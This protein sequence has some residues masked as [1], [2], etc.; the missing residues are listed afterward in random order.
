MTY[1]R[2]GIETVKE[3]LFPVFCLSCQ[4]EGAW[5]C[6]ACIDGVA[7][8]LQLFCPVCHR[9]THD[10]EVCVACAAES[11]L[12]RHVAMMKYQEDMLIGRLIH[13]LKYEYAEDTMRTIRTI[14]ASFVELHGDM[15]R[16]IDMIVPVPLHKKRFAERGFNQAAYIGKALA[17]KL[18]IAY[19][20]S[21]L[22]RSRYTPHQATLQRNERMINV[23]DAFI[24]GGTIWASL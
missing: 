20:G 8:D 16:N 2:E 5:I 23:E 1:L 4:A 22:V 9:G 11:S 12:I 10:G 15:F 21:L 18:D 14:I 7:V 6:D 19:D 13:T 3:Y 17:D 24:L